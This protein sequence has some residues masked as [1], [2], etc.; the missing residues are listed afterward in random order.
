MKN[1]TSQEIKDFVSSPLFDEKVLSKDNKSYPKISIITP[2]FNQAPFIE[3][4]IL[5]VLN[6]NYPNLEYIII[7]GNSTD[8]SVEIIKKYERYLAYWVSEKDEG[9]ADA[10]NKGLRM[11]TGELVGWQNS[12]DIYLPGALRTLSE[13]FQK[14]RNEDVFFGNVYLIDDEDNIIKDMR[15]T[16][17]DLDH[18]LYFNWNLSSQ[19]LFWRKELHAQ[20][21]YF[22]NYNVSFDLDWCIR[23]GKATRRFRHIRQFLGAYRMQPNSKF[24]LVKDE[25]RNRIFLKILAE[26]GVHIDKNR[27]YKKQH[28][29]MRIKLFWT[30]FFWHIVQGDF[31]YLF[32]RMI[33]RISTTL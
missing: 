22:K 19:G 26:S 20:L 18:L 8:K 21:G 31:G 9:Q 12:D 1:I 29:L 13:T 28:K 2:S 27:P 25:T 4:T 11:A 32:G 17:F 5:S 23:L 10:I 7:D 30:K 14:H 6:Q 3:R 16:P 24:A 15:F 33:Q